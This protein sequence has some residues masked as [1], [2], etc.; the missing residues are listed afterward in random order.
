MMLSTSICLTTL[1]SNALALGCGGVGGAG[2]CATAGAADRVSARAE[3]MATAPLR[4]RF[5]LC[6]LCVMRDSC[7]GSA[8]TRRYGATSSR[9]GHHSPQEGAETEDDVGHFRR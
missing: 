7:L 1:L 8:S 2:S 6:S 3:A 5:V 9:F 4:R